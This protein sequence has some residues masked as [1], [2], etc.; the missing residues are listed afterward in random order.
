V[1]WTLALVGFGNGSELVMTTLAGGSFSTG[2]L[3]NARLNNAGT[4][5]GAGAG[6]EGATWGT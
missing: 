4:L 6:T 2:W 5:A 1:G 3:F